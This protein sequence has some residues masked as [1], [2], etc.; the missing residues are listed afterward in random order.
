MKRGRRSSR[1]LVQDQIFNIISN[2]NSP[3]T[4]AFLTKEI[5][6]S[7]NKKISWNTV[8]KYINELVEIGK[9]QPIPLPHSK[10]ENKVGL[11]VYTLKK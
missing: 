10:E 5:S 9:I 3:V 7:L 1:R 6:K 2:V 8:Q 11:T 4:T